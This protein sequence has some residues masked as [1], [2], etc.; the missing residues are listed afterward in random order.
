MKSRFCETMQILFSIVGFPPSGS[1]QARLVDSYGFGRVMEVTSCEK[2]FLRNHANIVLRSRFP[3][4]ELVLK[5]F[6]SIYMFLKYDYGDSRGVSLPW[7][8]MSLGGE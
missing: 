5:P 2:S 1:Y 3:P 6:W 4:F 8:W 7:G